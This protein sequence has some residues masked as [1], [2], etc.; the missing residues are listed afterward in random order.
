M[1]RGA[2]KENLGGGFPIRQ[3]AFSN[4]NAF[5]PSSN[6]SSRAKTNGPQENKL[7][8]FLKK[9][10]ADPKSFQN[11][12][13][14]DPKAKNKSSR[15]LTELQTNALPDSIRI[16]QPSMNM[17]TQFSK[18][19]DEP[20][21]INPVQLQIIQE[22]P[23]SA[24]PQ[25][26]SVANAKSN[27]SAKTKSTEKTQTARPVLQP[28]SL[29]SQMP[30]KKIHRYSKT[31]Q[32]VGT[33]FI[34]EESENF[35]LETEPDNLQ[36]KERP[37][38]AQRQMPFVYAGYPSIQKRVQSVA[39]NKNLSSRSY[40]T[41]HCPTEGCENDEPS[42]GPGLFYS[43]SQQ[44]NLFSEQRKPEGV[45]DKNVSLGGDRINPLLEQFLKETRLK[46]LL[47]MDIEEVTKLRSQ[48]RELEG[49]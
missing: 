35:A 13:L 34:Q 26:N 33:A 1:N 47:Q 6:Y 28:A 15:I 10:N 25:P 16:D 2:N 17:E 41:A 46:E 18:P 14:S 27:P 20:L 19:A 22:R 32:A 4:N 5:T 38:S 48:N 9:V 49:N 29:V 23:R 42:T 21:L 3:G 31:P 39:S 11:V 8:S 12:Q 7:Q 40:I 43:H 36:V 44:D 45:K 30:K 24:T 37:K